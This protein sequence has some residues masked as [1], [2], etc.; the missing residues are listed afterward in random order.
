MVDNALASR[1]ESPVYAAD[2]P[3]A[4]EVSDRVVCALVQPANEVR[5]PDQV[6]VPDV[7]IYPER[8]SALERD[9][10]A[11]V[12]VVHVNP[13]RV[14]GEVRPGGVERCERVV[15]NPQLEGYQ[16]QAELL[17]VHEVV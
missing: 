16:A 5:G 10:G 3:P 12:V 13:V 4:G 11:D 6:E 9:F 14:F 2:I 17:L 8:R 7:R 1:C 15:E